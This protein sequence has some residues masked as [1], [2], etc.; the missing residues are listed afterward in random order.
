VV[1]VGIFRR[2]VFASSRILLATKNLVALKSVLVIKPFP[3]YVALTLHSDVH[4]LKRG[5]LPKIVARVNKFI[6]TAIEP[7]FYL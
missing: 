5:S 1:G 4:E 6:D 2:F 3:I 7:T